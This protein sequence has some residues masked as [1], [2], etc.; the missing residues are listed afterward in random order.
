MYYKD[1]TNIASVTT[2]EE[3]TELYCIDCAKELFDGV[4]N[5]E[6]EPRYTWENNE[7]DSPNHCP[8][9]GVLLEE[10]LTQ[11]GIDYVREA[12]LE[13]LSKPNTL[14]LDPDSPVGEWH[15]RWGSE[16]ENSR[17]VSEILD[18]ADA[19]QGYLESLVWTGTLDFMTGTHEQGGE[20]LT[21]GSLDNV[22]S[23]D[24]LTPDVVAAATSDVDSF[25]EQVGEY[26]KYWEL[27]DHLTASQLGH[28]FNLTRN[29]HGAGFWDRGYGE[30]GDWLTRVAQAMGSQSLYGSVVVIDLDNPSLERDNLDMSTLSVYLEG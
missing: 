25:I 22:Y 21:S 10:S 11:Q 13:E 28:D 17:D 20:C 1:L 6:I 12:V 14:A 3:L 23:V 30:L 19:L 5:V 8:N 26:L 4:E 24:D 9:C 27:P 2:N 7:T 29:H 15:A 18:N 16:I